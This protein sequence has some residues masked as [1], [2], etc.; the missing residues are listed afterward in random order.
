MTICNPGQIVLVTFPFTTGSTAKNRPA[1]VLIDHGD[2]DLLLARITTQSHSTA[3]DCVIQDWRGAG[4]LAP[5]IARLC[6]LATLDKSLVKRVIGALQPSDKMAV[7][8]VLQSL[9]SSW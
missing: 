3:N 9:F 1:L 5:S 7:K 2:N 4:L 6:K 8:A